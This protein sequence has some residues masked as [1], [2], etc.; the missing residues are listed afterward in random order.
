MIGI[1]DVTVRAV[2]QH[3]EPAVRRVE[4][5]ALVVVVGEVEPADEGGAVEQSCRV[6]VGEQGRLRAGVAV[7]QAVVVFGVRGVRDL[8]IAEDAV[9]ELVPA[10]AADAFRLREGEAQEHVLRGM[11]VG[12]VP[13]GVGLG[14]GVRLRHPDLL[15]P[16]L[17]DERLEPA[18]PA[19][20]VPV[21]AVRARIHG[22][23]RNVV[24]REVAPARVERDP[25]D[26]VPSAGRV[27]VLHPR[28][29][30]AREPVVQELER[31]PGGDH[32]IVDR[33]QRLVDVRLRGG[34]RVEGAVQ[35][36]ADLEVLGTGRHGG[37]G[38]GGCPGRGLRSRRGQ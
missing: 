14:A 13:P 31:C 30:H 1:E 2:P 17:R 29:I 38:V 34:P 8:R 28:L 19:E 26:E 33:A 11:P 36:V 6:R 21:R 32:A 35:L 9:V 27:E 20:E 4:E 10:H 16:V 15:R 12:V 23:L 37:R 7:H 22:I 25:V 18:E 24:G 3:R 5:Q